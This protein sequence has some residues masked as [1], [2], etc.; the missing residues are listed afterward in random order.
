MRSAS[1]YA[2]TAH[3]HSIIIK[4]LFCSL[5]HPCRLCIFAQLSFYQLSLT[6]AGAQFP[7][8]Y[9]MAQDQFEYVL[10]RLNPNPGEKQ[11]SIE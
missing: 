1:R 6:S 3:R 7:Y 8:A 5:S 9:K 10:Q 11:L 2:S 4:H